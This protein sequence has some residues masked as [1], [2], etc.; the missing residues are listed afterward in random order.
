[1]WPRDAAGS[2][3]LDGGTGPITGMCNCGEFMEVYKI[4]TTFRIKSPETIDPERTN[5][6]APWVNSME[7]GVGSSHHAVARVLMQ[8]RQLLDG[9]I[10]SPAPDKDAV[11]R[12]LHSIKEELVVCDKVATR[13]RN[14]VES[15][16]AR[17]QA[18]NIPSSPPP[19]MLSPFPQVADLDGEATTFLIRAKRA[20][21]LMCSLP[22]KFIDVPDK[23][24][25]F[26]YLGAT[27]KGKLGADSPVTQLI[28]SH[29]ASVK[30]LIELRNF[31]EHPSS[32][33][34]TVVKNFHV[35][36]DGGIGLPEWQV[37]GSTAELIHADMSEAVP[38]LIVTAELLLAHLVSHVI[39]PKWSLMRIEQIP[40]EQQNAA[41][42]VRLRMS[43][44][45]S[46]LRLR[47][48]DAPEGS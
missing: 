33:K 28:E 9:G 8:G 38:F 19:R 37:T 18:S 14:S 45:T 15:I 1:M 47:E 20:I 43:M 7:E 48:P 40:V 16:A 39:D 34:S 4:D 25:N 11:V 5:P 3:K 10:F 2:F 21:R 17:I 23:D 44:D 41:A 36:P 6:Q 42:P 26:E 12:L 24:S 13:V 27:V 30:H 22:S 31:Q 35:M 29:A 46:R 32:G